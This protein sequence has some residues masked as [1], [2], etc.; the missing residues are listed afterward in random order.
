[1]LRRAVEREE[2]GHGILAPV[3]D[4]RRIGEVGSIVFQPV[5]DGTLVILHLARKDSH[6]A[7]VVDSLV[8]VALQQLLRLHILG[9]DEQSAGVAV[10]AVD[11][12][13]RT[14]LLRLV[15]IVVEDGLD[16]ARLMPGSH[17]QDAHVLVHHDE[18]LVLVDQLQVAAAQHQVVAFRLAHGHLHSWCEGI[19]E[20][21][22]RLAVDADATALQ[23]LL[24][25]RATLT[26]E[27]LQE[28]LQQG[29][30]ALHYIVVPLA[31]LRNHLI[32]HTYSAF[33][34]KGTIK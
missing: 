23:R 5:G 26:A 22:H 24:H 31:L 1:M 28:K 4:R 12:M 27:C 25:L 19:V 3:V 7:T 16:V 8:P 10:Q 14:A 2:M 18:P 32:F 20:L 30:F 6:I 15:E 11:D 29:L 13:G 21:R 33:A 17:R 34:C 9:V